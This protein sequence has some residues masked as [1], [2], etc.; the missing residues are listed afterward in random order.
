MKRI[1]LLVAI[2]VMGSVPL[3]HA[4]N[5]GEVGAFVDYFHLS[6]ENVF[7]ASW[8]SIG[9]NLSP[10]PTLSRFFSHRSPTRRPQFAGRRDFDC[11]SV[12]KLRFDS[13]LGGKDIFPG[14]RMTET[15]QD[16][17]RC[18]LSRVCVTF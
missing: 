2:A 15:K 6:S 4:Q 16:L 18:C 1:A 12:Y 9:P 17:S 13:L 8:P 7:I 11:S 10:K 14:G 3:A 5:H